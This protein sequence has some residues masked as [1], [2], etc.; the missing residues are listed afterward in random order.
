MDRCDHSEPGL[1]KAGI[2]ALS[3]WLPEKQGEMQRV[4]E[5]VG[6]TLQEQGIDSTNGVGSVLD[7]EM[8][9]NH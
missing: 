9:I 6:S 8:M 1:V 5:A 4:A 2:K 7:K 3:E